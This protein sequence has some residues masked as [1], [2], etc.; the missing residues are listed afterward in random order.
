MTRPLNQDLRRLFGL[1]GF[2]SLKLFKGCSI[3]PFE[4]RGPLDSQGIARYLAIERKRCH[5]CTLENVGCK[6]PVDS[7]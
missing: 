3:L 2:P 4:Y 6:T 5:E 1:R 7:F